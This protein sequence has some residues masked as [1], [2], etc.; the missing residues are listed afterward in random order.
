MPTNRL[1][2]K[3]KVATY[4]S[5]LLDS[6]YAAGGQDAVLEVRDQS[7]QVFRIMRSNIDLLSTF[8]DTSY[9]AQER[10]QVARAV[11]ADCNPA[12]LDVLVVMAERRDFGLLRHV[13]ENYKCA[14]EEKLDVRVVDVTTVVELDD[15]LREVIKNKAQADLGKEVV[16]RERIDPS[17]LGGLTMSTG[18]V[19]IDASVVSQLEHARTVL[20]DTTDG[21]EC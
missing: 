18:D 7:E 13:W 15:H 9:T 16:L 8:E 2:E 14:L 1:L 20:K 11:F 12:L 10:G 19:Y 21:G 17:L 5:V 6:A 3:E 4:V